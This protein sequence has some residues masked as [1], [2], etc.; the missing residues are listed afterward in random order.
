MN[1]LKLIGL[2]KDNKPARVGK[3][4]VMYRNEKNSVHIYDHKT[5]IKVM[6]LTD[7]YYLK[8][9]PK[10]NNFEGKCGDHKVHCHLNKIT[11]WIGYWS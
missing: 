6:T 4:V 7:T 11:G 2:N 9:N 5:S 3:D 8:L 10:T 1:V